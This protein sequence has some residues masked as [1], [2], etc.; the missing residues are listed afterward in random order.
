[1]N[2]DAVIE[3]LKSENDASQALVEHEKDIVLNALTKISSN[4]HDAMYYKTALNGDLYY[5]AYFGY[6]LSKI[7]G[8]AIS[9]K[10]VKVAGD[11]GYTYGMHKTLGRSNRC[12]GNARITWYDSDNYFNMLNKTCVNLIEHPV[13]KQATEDFLL[14]KNKLKEDDLVD[15][16]ISYELPKSIPVDVVT[17][18]TISN[19]TGAKYNIVANEFVANITEVVFVTVLQGSH[20]N[21]MLCFI[22][23][24]NKMK[25]ILCSVDISLFRQ[26]QGQGRRAKFNNH[27]D[28]A[29][30][31][32]TYR[33]SHPFSNYIKTN[34]DV[35]F[36]NPMQIINDEL[37]NTVKNLVD[38][39]CKNAVLLKKTFNYLKKKYLKQMILNGELCI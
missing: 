37:V 19:S 16:F 8:K 28:Y 32:F 13:K 38:E 34:N 25:E 2:N 14:L 6:L 24:N 35:H 31:Y 15:D 4:I 10:R 11:D 23:N 39:K 27:N 3:I 29:Y 17:F 21:T 26:T 18:N 9:K 20:V 12:Y 30:N 7:Y 5:Q 33:N 36:A 22:H 1:M